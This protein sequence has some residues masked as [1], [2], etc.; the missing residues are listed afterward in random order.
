MEGRLETPGTQAQLVDMQCI[1]RFSS[2]QGILD[3]PTAIKTRY[4]R[5]PTRTH[6]PLAPYL[7][8][9]CAEIVIASCEMMFVMG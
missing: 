4:R 1:L 2:H 9:W 7:G 5:R 6:L 3:I 8:S